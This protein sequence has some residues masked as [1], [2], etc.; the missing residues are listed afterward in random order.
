VL[1]G[2]FV[3][4]R[5]NKYPVI[6]Y[7]ITM[8]S[9]FGLAG[10]TGEQD[11]TV[12][13]LA[14]AY[15]KR[16]IPIVPA[17]NPP[18]MVDPDV[19]NPAAFDVVA[20]EQGGDV[21]VRSS[22]SPSASEQNITLCLTDPDVN[23]DLDGVGTGDVKDLDSSFDGEKL[24]FAL[25][26]EDFFPNND[27]IPPP[28]WNIY[29]YDVLIGGCP[30]RVI[31]SDFEAEKG[32]DL[33]PVYLPDG[34]IIFT[35]SRQ[36]LV[37]A[38]QLD[39]GNV[40]FPPQDENQ[41]EDSLVLHVMSASGTG[42]KQIS[43][44]QS[45]D[46]DPSV[47]SSGEIVFS[48]WDN[49]GTSN[50]INL[51]KIRPDGTELK[52]LYGVH[53]HNVGTGGSTVQFLSPRELDDGRILG[54]IKPFNGSAGGGAPVLINVVQ[55]A[56]NNQ[57]IWPYQ[58]AGLTGDGQ[59]NAVAI[60]VTTDASISP[61]GRF[62]S[63]YPLRDGTNRALVSWTQCRLQPVDAMGLPLPDPPVPCPGTIPVGAVEAFPIYG[64][65]VYDLSSNTQLPVVIP[66][67]GFIFDEP[68][69]FAARPEPTILFDKAPV[70]GFGLDPTLAT[71]KVGLLHIRSV[72]DFDGGFNDL[73]AGVADLAAMS[74][75]TQ[76]DAD[77]RPARFLRIVKGSYIPSTDVHD[78][79]DRDA[80]FGLTRIH[81]MREIL[82]YVP[83]EPDGSVLA[84]VPANVPFA[85]SVVDKDGRRLGG[86]HQN[87][88]Q[89]QS[90]EV[91]EC[92]GCHDHSPLAPAEPLPHGYSDN[93]VVL[94][95]GAPVAGVAFTG[96]DPL[97][98]PEMN[99]TMALTRIRT[100]CGPN[101]SGALGLN[102]AI[103]TCSALSP[104]LDMRFT[105][106]WADPVLGT[107]VADLDI[108]YGNL[109]VPLSPPESYLSINCS[110]TSNP[111]WVPWDQGCRTIINYEA[112]IHPLWSLP[113]AAGVR[114]CTNCHINAGVV[115]DAQLDL[116]DGPS[117]QDSDHFKAY[118]ELLFMDN[119]VDVNGLDVTVDQIVQDTDANGDPLFA[120]DPIT[121]L[122]EP[123]FITIQVPVVAQGPSVSVN[124]SRAGTFMGKFL[125][126]GTHAGDLTL[127]E[128]RL[129]AEWI[130][131]GAQ[132][133]N[134]P[135]DAPEN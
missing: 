63:V 30:T 120:I 16:P 89:L 107:P 111:N 73:G 5:L 104:E 92:N 43:F 85:I 102:V 22:A 93:P 79:A 106:E 56:D 134:R 8:L 58:N 19:R 20:G 37:G 66:V 128:I 47:L 53:A 10:C 67:E 126:G 36:D 125:L 108:L 40:Q 72:Y 9:V 69:V 52:A 57:P 97:V 77:V 91:L 127:E 50:A 27:M 116:T 119:E 21:Y 41:N 13:D 14:I 17:S 55:Y 123:V 68:V 39:E 105:D 130:D 83:I 35:S 49:M 71:E 26:L 2:G 88:L 29:E 95:M 86:R 45:H 113:R 54:M 96:T 133:Y 135:F 3:A 124:G 78:F 81:G 98:L 84:K 15:V 61:A 62:R 42:I 132:Y 110:D 121:G 34:R 70:A 11:Q 25:R 6:G 1:T 112:H 87:W 74:D 38:I 59:I 31:V 23:G 80:A 24:I 76:A 115:P 4:S 109:P 118:R 103:A 75:P 60:G 64:I 114:T 100:A 82:G 101:A 99:D 131:L 65:Y 7:L 51:F 48:R 90:G 122:L 46:L 129:L 44:N 12:A 33:G 28:T 117:D 94:N 18:Q 32:N